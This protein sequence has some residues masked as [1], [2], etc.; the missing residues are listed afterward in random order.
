VRERERER[1]RERVKKEKKKREKKKSEELRELLS[2]AVQHGE[3]NDN[4]SC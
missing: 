2:G 1:E 3:C 4:V